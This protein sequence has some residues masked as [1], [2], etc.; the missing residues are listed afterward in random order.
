MRKYILAALFFAFALAVLTVAHAMS[1]Q[2]SSFTFEQ[3]CKN[4]GCIWCA[5]CS[6]ATDAQSASSSN[7]YYLG[8]NYLAD[9]CV[10]TNLECTYSC[11]TACGANCTANSG[12]PAN[13]T[14][15][16]CSY[17]GYC[18]A[19]EC[20]YKKAP[21]PK[22]GR[23]VTQ[24]DDARICYYGNRVCGFSGCFVN[25][26]SLRE[27]EICEP[28][29]GCIAAEGSVG[30]YL[31]DYRCSG[32]NLL[33][34]KVIYVCNATECLFNRTDAFVQQCKNGCLYD[35]C[36]DEICNIEGR[37]YDCNQLDGYYGGRFCKGK[38]V[39][40][41]YRDYR[42]VANEC[43]FT[44]K[45]TK[46]LA[47]DDCKNGVCVE[48]KT[49]TVVYTNQPDQPDSGESSLPP[50]RASSLVHPGGR[51]YNGFFF[52]ANRIILNVKGSG[53]VNFT[54]TKTN[55]LGLLLVQ[56]G[57]KTLFSTRQTGR[58]SIPFTNATV[59]TL[60]ATSSGAI[61]FMPATYDARNIVAVY[62]SSEIY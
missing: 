55:K 31:T 24:A 32:D 28:D 60:T 7:R 3:G 16:G 2:C 10:N 23:I 61:F 58:Y 56:S 18:S 62:K 51:L 49:E 33:A 17:D 9:K 15:T 53:Y 27:N 37:Q 45:E 40:A 5:K 35:A 48:N 36:K 30:E 34:K 4:A 41:A 20:V 26:C 43:V 19:C 11:S 59:I 52:G 38:D 50:A 29:K 46:Q 21:C 42:C 12:C 6:G 57:R 1:V 25:S 54:V 13:L 47:C 22:P 44:A 8:N 14:D 39:Y